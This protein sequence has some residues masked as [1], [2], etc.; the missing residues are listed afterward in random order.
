MSE[1]PK[2]FDELKE[3]LK[4]RL[5]KEPTPGTSKA[6]TDVYQPG[7]VAKIAEEIGVGRVR[8]TAT[9][10]RRPAN[11]LTAEEYSQDLIQRFNAI[12]KAEGDQN[13]L[14]IFLGAKDSVMGYPDNVTRAYELA[15]K[16]LFPQA[17]V[18]PSEPTLNRHAR[19]IEDDTPKP[20]GAEQSPR[21]SDL[22][23]AWQQGGKEKL[24]EM[25]ENMPE[26]DEE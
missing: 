16:Q 2:S 13:L 20:I 24:R 6:P 7:Y 23:R 11:P 15:E 14:Q 25:L 17:A 9:T 21:P 12:R 1:I 4:S 5:P 3:L 10:S 26:E 19:L 22:F 18:V 8:D